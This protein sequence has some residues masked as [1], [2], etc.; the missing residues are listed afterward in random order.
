MTQKHTFGN[1]K[2]DINLI[3]DDPLLK[4]AHNLY[5]LAFVI[6]MVRSIRK[7]LNTLIGKK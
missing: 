7:A 1:Y 4:M 2:T 6:F 3:L 5:S